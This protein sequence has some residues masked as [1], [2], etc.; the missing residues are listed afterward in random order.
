MIISF[1]SFMISISLGFSMSSQAK[2]YTEKTK[3]SMI[4]RLD[5]H[6]YVYD[7]SS[8]LAAKKS[9]EK[10]WSM[11]QKYKHL[12]N[13]IDT[14]HLYRIFNQQW[15]TMTHT[16]DPRCPGPQHSHLTIPKNPRPPL[17]PPVNLPRHPPP[18]FW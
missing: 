8:P 3:E 5:T 4:T 13:L 14:R 10:A 1:S 16:D 18:P 9:G 6:L 15:Y 12:T 11:W 7:L 17:F 2:A